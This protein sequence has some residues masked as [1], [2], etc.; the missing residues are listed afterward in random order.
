MPLWLKV[1][2]FVFEIAGLTIAG[3]IV[4]CRIISRT[5][6]YNWTSDP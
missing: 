3:L 4:E 5:R 2:M 6:Q 1:V